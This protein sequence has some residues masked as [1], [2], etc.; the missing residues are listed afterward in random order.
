MVSS[1]DVRIVCPS[2]FFLFAHMGVSLGVS[3]TFSPLVE[4]FVF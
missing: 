4:S 1:S 2:I 3:Y